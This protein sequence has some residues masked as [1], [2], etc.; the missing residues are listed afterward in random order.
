[1]LLYNIYYNNEKINNRPISAE[2]LE[3]IKQ[4]E[5]IGKVNEVTKDVTR[6]PTNKVNIIKC[7]MV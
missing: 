7:Y 4:R 6:I 1:M 3:Q 5:Y 2:E